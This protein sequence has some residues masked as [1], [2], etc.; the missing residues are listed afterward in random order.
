M[1]MVGGGSMATKGPCECENAK[2]HGIC[3]NKG[4]VIIHTIYGKYRI[5]VACKI[6]HPIPKEFL[7]R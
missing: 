3:G 5:C 1:I 6:N 4:H 2:H 7:K